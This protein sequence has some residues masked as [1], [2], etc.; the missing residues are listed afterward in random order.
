M[1]YYS[2]FNMPSVFE[3]KLALKQYAETLFVDIDAKHLDVLIANVVQE[4]SNMSLTGYGIFGHKDERD[5]LLV[6][7]GINK[8]ITKNGMRF[9]LFGN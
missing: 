6:A 8:N 5:R 2:N 3:R 1:D 4:T 7:L 9:N